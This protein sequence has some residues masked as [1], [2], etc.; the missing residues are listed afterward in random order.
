M[1]PGA[2]PDRP[3][4]EQLKKQAK[5]LLHAAKA[6]DPVA[7]RRFTVLP[8]LAHKSDTELAAVELALHGRYSDD[9]RGEVNRGTVIRPRA[10]RMP[11]RRLSSQLFFRHAQTEGE[12]H[13][14][15]CQQCGAL[16]LPPDG[17]LRRVLPSH[18]LKP[19]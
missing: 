19:Q 1:S 5:S 10:P 14:Y 18:T 13:L 3:N 12:T 9:K 11:V 17:R 7:L 2:L 8:A 16:A 4:L 6:N 15:V